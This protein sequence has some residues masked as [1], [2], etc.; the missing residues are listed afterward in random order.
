MCR[1]TGLISLSC[2]LSASATN[3]TKQCCS[4]IL[5]LSQILIFLSTC[6][7]SSLKQGF[8]LICQLHSSDELLNFVGTICIVIQVHLKTPVLGKELSNTCFFF[9][10]CKNICDRIPVAQEIII[11]LILQMLKF[12]QLVNNISLLSVG[13]K[14]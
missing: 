10:S 12:S 6:R 4:H 13:T 9:K 1:A 7:R 2:L 8:G 3:H 11:V 5:F 14:S